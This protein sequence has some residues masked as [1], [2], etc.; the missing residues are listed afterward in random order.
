MK[1]VLL[2]VIILGDS[3]VG[4]TALMTQYVMKKFSFTYKTTIGADFMAKELNVDDHI[5]VLQIWDTAGQ[6]RFKSLGTA[7]YR[8]ADACVLVFDINAPKSWDNV[9]AWRNEFISEAG[10]TDPVSYPFV[11]V[12]NKI[13][14]KT[15]D[16]QSV[17]EKQVE[18]WCSE[19][20]VPLLFTSAKDGTNVDTLFAKV[21]DRALVN[22][23]KPEQK[24][25]PR[26]D[27][28]PHEETQQGGCCT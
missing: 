4:K 14:A 11:I 1:K 6:D 3:G 8:G 20:Q 17:S 16:V 12:G 24:E 7:F 9:E 5:V 15:D 2:K 28:T 22:Y 18:A 26:L 23:I 21:V 27:L 19:H 25:K 13:D 10:I